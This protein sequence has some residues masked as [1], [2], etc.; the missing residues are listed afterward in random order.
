MQGVV[1]DTVGELL[2]LVLYA[3]I[4]AV[5]AVLGAVTE[6]AS[7]QDIAAGQSLFGLWEVAVGTLLLYAAYNVV[8]DF[9][10]PGLRGERESNA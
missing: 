9:V 4:A 5:L 7:V 2:G 1:T 6:L 10:V 3:G 8:T